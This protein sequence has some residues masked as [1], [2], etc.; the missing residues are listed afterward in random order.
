MSY[1]FNLYI[2]CVR[3]SLRMAKDAQTKL[4]KGGMVTAWTKTMPGTGITPWHLT[5]CLEMMEP[6]CL[7]TL[8]STV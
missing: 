8:L 7:G 1:T 3:V 5:F 4:L 2:S 6:L